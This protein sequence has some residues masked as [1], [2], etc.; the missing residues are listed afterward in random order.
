MRTSAFT[1]LRGHV[2]SAGTFSVGALGLVA[3]FGLGLELG[4][5]LSVETCARKSRV[6]V[7]AQILLLSNIDM[8]PFVIN[9]V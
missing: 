5:K 6:P 4:R 9:L 3:F 7:S 8:F 1:V 2:F